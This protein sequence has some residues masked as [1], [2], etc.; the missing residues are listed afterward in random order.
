[1]LADSARQAAETRVQAQ[2][3]TYHELADAEVQSSERY[4]AYQDA[5]FEYQ[6]A[7]MNLLRATGDLESWAL[8]GSPAGSATK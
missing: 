5:D 4:L 6:R 1:E 8:P 3:G 2:T 7:R